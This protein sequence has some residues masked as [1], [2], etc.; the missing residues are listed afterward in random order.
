[1]SRSPAGCARASA[2]SS[3]CRSP[4]RTNRPKL[5]LGYRLTV[6]GKV[7]LYSG[8]TGW[9]E[10]AGDAVAAA[11]TCSSAS[12]ASTRRASTST[13]TIRASPRSAPASAASAWCSRT[14]AARS[15]RTATRSA[16]RSPPTASSSSSEARGLAAARAR[17]GGLLRRQHQ[18]ALG[19]LR[20]LLR[21]RAGRSRRSWRAPSWLQKRNLARQR[22]RRRAR[23]ATALACVGALGAARGGEDS[24]PSPYR[25]RAHDGAAARRRTSVS[26][27]RAMMSSKRSC[28]CISLSTSGLSCTLPSS[29]RNGVRSSAVEEP[30][31]QLGLARADRRSGERARRRRAA[32]ST[33]RA[34]RR[35][36][37]GRLAQ[38][39]ARAAPDSRLPCACRGAR[40]Q[41]KARCTRKSA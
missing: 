25:R 38:E 32:A 17:A 35:Q 41:S 11:P 37:A 5:S 22:D 33:P 2:P 34:R 9:T 30:G 36:L 31:A 13:S 26:M 39:L 28:C 21:R 3:C 19:A 10:D 4:C 14:S 27:A 12:A 15:S 1:M 6:D 20:L 29:S 24:A 23:A 40:R 8:D 16:R 7:V 18:R